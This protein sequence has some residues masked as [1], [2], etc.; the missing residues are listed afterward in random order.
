MAVEAPPRGPETRASRLRLAA[1]DYSLSL[2]LVLTGSFLLAI[3]ARYLLAREIVTPWIMADELIYSEMAKN[4]A[5]SG[6]FLLRET[7]SP[8]NNVA[9]PTLISPAWFAEPIETAYG[10]AR[11][12]NVW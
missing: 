10:L 2:A 9:Y 5:D 11:F 7:P 4:F 8:L 12:I 6:E 3:A 1:P